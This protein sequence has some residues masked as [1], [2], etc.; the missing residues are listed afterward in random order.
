MKRP[1]QISVRTR[2]RR[3]ALWSAGLALCLGGVSAAAL[4][5][6]SQR[7]LDGQSIALGTANF[8]LSA[9]VAHPLVIG[10]MGTLLVTIHNS[11]PAPIRVTDI[12]VHAVSLFNQ[13]CRGSWVQARRYLATRTTG[14]LVAANGVRV[15]R[16]PIHL[17]DLTGTNQTLCRHLS[18]PLTLIGHAVTIK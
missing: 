18:V 7:P 15:M 1:A 5:L 14:A 4:G 11:Y 16:L 2:I 3:G 6:P 17:V 9:K 10:Q 12:Q 8:S 13:K